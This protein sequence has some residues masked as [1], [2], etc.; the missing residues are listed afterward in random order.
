MRYWCI[1]CL[2]FSFNSVFSQNQ[3]QDEV[4]ASIATFFKGFHAQ[5]SVL[6]KSVL[7]SNV[8]MQ[9]IGKDE[10]GK[11]TIIPQKITDFL[12]SIVS[13]P[14]TMKFEEKILSYSIQIDGDMANAWTPYEFW[15]NDTFSHCGVNSFQLVKEG[16]I[17]K[18]IYIIDT[19]RK[20][21]CVQ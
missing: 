10:L 5:D 16:E 9:R 12:K 13:I 15:R 17:W 2:I 4:K 18:I 19:R 8:I 11:V 21:N 6:I 14:K 3:E 1:L 7:S 20:E